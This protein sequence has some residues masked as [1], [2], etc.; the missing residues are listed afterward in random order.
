MLLSIVVRINRPAPIITST[1]L[2]L[3]LNWNATISIVFSIS[4]TTTSK[5]STKRIALKTSFACILHI[6][7]SNARMFFVGLFFLHGFVS[8]FSG[9][10]PT[11]TA[12]R[13]PS[14][15]PLIA[16]K[17]RAMNI[18]DRLSSSDSGGSVQHHLRKNSTDKSTMTQ[19]ERNAPT[20]G[21]ATWNRSVKKRRV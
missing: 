6:H 7:R 12:S 5:K 14:R 2:N 21:Y 4:I 19:A 15:R 17:L 1:V 16:P 13:G 9:S 10:L 3:F 18:N 8:F 20:N 11:S